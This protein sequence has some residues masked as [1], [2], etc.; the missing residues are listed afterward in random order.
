MYLK[1]LK[2]VLFLTMYFAMMLIHWSLNASEVVT[3]LVVGDTGFAPNKMPVNPRGVIGKSGS[4]LTWSYSTENILSDI[5]GDLNFLNVE[6]VVTDR[7]DLQ[8]DLK[9]QKGPFNFRTHPNALEHLYDIGFNVFS[10]ANNHSMD[11]GVEGLFDTLDN[12]KSLNR[13]G[14]ILYGGIGRNL[15]EAGRPVVMSVKGFDVAFSSI[16]IITNNLS[17]HRVGE[18][19]AGQI[20]Y[21]FDGD[22]QIS[23][24]RLSN[25]D[26]DYRILSI[27]Y[28]EEGRVRTDQKQINEWR[29]QA[30]KES[31]IDLVIGHHAHVVRGVEVVDGKVIF[32]GLGNFLHHGTSNISQKGPCRSYGLLAKVHLL[33][34]KNGKLVARAIE[35]IPVTNTHVRPGRYANPEESTQ[36]LYALNYLAGFLDNENDGAYGVRF[37]PQSDG[38]G[39]YCLNGAQSDPGIIGE[40]CR[41]WKPAPQIPSHYESLI[42]KD[43]SR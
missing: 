1:K 20:A 35:A 40:L 10:L 23:K 21:R 26:A 30:I 22:Y 4:L 42:Q 27:H 14:D 12:M 39:L 13:K 11:Y 19:K 32:Y 36:R 8:A 28:G 15:E 6:T 43:C 38:S 24:K 5:D 34:N 17:R 29:K 7:N 33:K 2:T 3:I 16:G 37:T 31:N 9:G 18:N 25:T 41:T